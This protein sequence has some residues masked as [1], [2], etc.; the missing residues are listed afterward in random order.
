MTAV[1]KW[2]QMKCLQ[3]VTLKQ[4]NIY[5]DNPFIK[6]Q[7]PGSTKRLFGKKKIA[8]IL[9]QKWHNQNKWSGGRRHHSKL[10]GLRSRP[11]Q[12][13]IH[14]YLNAV[15]HLHS[16]KLLKTRKSMPRFWSEFRAIFDCC[17][18][19]RPNRK[20]RKERRHFSTLMIIPLHEKCLQFDWLRAVVFQLHLKYLHV[21]ITNLLCV[22]V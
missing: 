7:F 12:M 17:Q 18:S 15:R 5:R 4:T 19:R 13:F 9:F 8:L 14:L 20:K 22:V 1:K 16:Y 2:R 6:A 10:C 11:H 21:K 3:G